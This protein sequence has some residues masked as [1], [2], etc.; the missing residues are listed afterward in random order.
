MTALA[1]NSKHLQQLA[2]KLTPLQY[3]VTQEK[4]TEKW[5]YT[6]PSSSLDFDENLIEFLI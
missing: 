6:N 2:S 4:Y 1:N 3:K 5:V